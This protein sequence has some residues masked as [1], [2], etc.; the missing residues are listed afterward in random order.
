MSLLLALG[1]TPAGGIEW[2]FQLTEDEEPEQHEDILVINVF[3]EQIGDVLYSFLE[4]EEEEA[5]NDE[6]WIGTEYLQEVVVPEIPATG[7][8]GKEPRWPYPI[9]PIPQDTSWDVIGL[10]GIQSRA[11]VSPVTIT[12]YPRDKSKRREEELL[13]LAA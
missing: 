9:E 10:G 12:I 3:D 7:G 6:I 13:L 4:D 11:Y 5:A 1:G 2:F 8:G